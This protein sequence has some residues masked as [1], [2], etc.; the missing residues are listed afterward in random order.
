MDSNH[1]HYE[2]IK[3]S[4]EYVLEHFEEQPNLDVLAERVSLSP[5]HFQKVF[6]TWAGV[7]PKEFLQFVTVTHAKHLLKE[8]NL[9]ETTYSLGLSSTGRLH[10]LFVKLEAM[11]PGEFKR[12]GEGLI[13]QYEVFPSSFGEILLVSSERGIQSL[14][15]IDTLEQGISDTKKEFPNAIWKEGSSE[16]HKKIKDYFQKFLIPETPIPL[17]LYGTEFQFKVW[18]SLLKIPMGNLCTYGDIAE[19]IRQPSAQRAVGTAIGKNPIAYLIP[20]HRVIQTSG[21]F[22]GYRWNPNR[23]RMIIAWEQ[24]KLSSP[25]NELS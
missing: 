21:L 14:Q 2:I 11:T 4:I 9:L 12:G 3:N 25:N 10:D 5:F 17:Y 6:R 13:L 22:G 16:E 8:S 19:S 15:F 23:K 7:S 24:S 18:K 1:K 20:C